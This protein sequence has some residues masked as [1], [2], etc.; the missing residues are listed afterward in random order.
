MNEYLILNL[1]GAEQII[2]SENNKN[3]SSSN[4]TGN[5]AVLGWYDNHVIPCHLFVAVPAIAK[6]CVTA[7]HSTHTHPTIAPPP[8][9]LSTTF[10]CTTTIYTAILCLLFI[11][12][13][14]FL[15]ITQSIST[16]QQLNIS[17]ATLKLAQAPTRS[18]PSEVQ[19]NR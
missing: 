13:S 18:A 14:E 12:S 3:N 15:H 4:N 8:T 19:A 7:Q 1:T 17:S 6:K 16:S 10:T 5:K 9:L 11:P 2:I